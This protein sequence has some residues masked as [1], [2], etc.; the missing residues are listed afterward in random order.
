[1]KHHADHYLRFRPVYPS[2]LFDSF[3]KGFLRG[4]PAKILDVACGTGQSVSSLAKAAQERKVAPL[5]L[6]ACD[7]DPEMIAELNRTIDP[8]L[9][10]QTQVAPAEVLPFANESFGGIIC[11]SA[12]HWF[13]REKCNAEWLRILKPAGA[14]LIGEYQFPKAPQNAALNEWT[15]RQFNLRWKFPNQKPR[16]K[17]KELLK[18]LQGHPRMIRI[19]WEHHT[20][21]TDFDAHEFSGLIQSQ[22]RFISTFDALVHPDLKQKELERIETETREFFSLGKVSFEFKFQTALLQT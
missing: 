21:T 4:D 14:L 11:L 7:I 1:V 13:D 5:E 19:T 9:L 3:L 2:N 16:G 8:S 20:H 18:D 15:R 22:A 17:L 6:H 12:Y 10:I